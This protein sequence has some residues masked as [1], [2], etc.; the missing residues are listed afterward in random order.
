MS[1]H[2]PSPPADSLV[3][4]KVHPARVVSVGE[5]IEIAL[6]GGQSK[7]VRAKDLELLHPGPLRSLG[8]LVP[9]EGEVEAAWE[10]LEGS[11][12]SLQELAELA[13]S[14]FT[15]V[16]AWA[17]WQLV[18]EGLS[19][20]GT[21]GAIR[22]RPRAEVEYDRAQRDAK[23]VAEREWQAFLGRMAQAAPAPQDAGRLTEVE[24]LALGQS[25]RSRVLEALGH[26]QTPVNAHRALI[27]V[28]HWSDRHN[29]YPGR[30]S[31]PTAD[32]DLPVPAL[33]D[34]QRLDLTDLPA[35]AI[36][37]EGNQDPDD[38]VSLD[39]DRLW[40]HVADVAAL[41]APDGAVEREARARG[42]N[43]YLPERVINMLPQ[44]VTEQLGLGLQPVSPALSIALRCDAQGELTDIEVHRTWIRAQRLTYDAVDGRLGEAP[45]AAMCALTDRFRARRVALGAISLDLPEV[46]V[47]VVD[48]RVTIR[49]LPRL[50]S[51][52]LVTEAMLMAGE[53]VARF[54]RE[55]AIPI[56]Y[57][58]QVAPDAGDQPR[59]LAAMY[60]RR[61]TFKPTR[62]LI[63]PDLHAGLGLPLYT[64]ATSPLR[65]YSDLL[66]HQQ[67]CAWLSGQ[68]LLTAEQVTERIGEAEAAAG[69]VRRAER[70]SNLHWKLVFLKDHPDWQGEAIIV[71]KEE[72]KGVALIG[73]LALE[74]RLR[75]RD[76]PDLNQG[77]RVAVREV[78]VPD[79]T[80]SFRVL[81]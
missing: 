48:G 15:P 18:A 61:R 42:S 41:V 73:A 6:E 46:S 77:I 27:Q 8:E 75:L 19:F 43:L 30:C 9:Q 29:P 74:T 76:E 72:R 14:A 45:F 66:V 65:R 67:L 50:A 11:E 26:E 3:L 17:A 51:R 57:A 78:D 12:T 34:Q 33:P 63:I 21:P 5:K 7:R 55:H 32:P 40:V 58:T 68:P 28:G 64:R 71:G 4:Y 31:V 79:Q 44:G 56:S 16:T 53:G 70:L 54:C 52:G 20:T 1:S 59:D 10:L 38:A 62:M 81:G 23:A 39:G 36:D 80:V 35:Y 22:A 2:Q 24:R 69:T 49:P 13:F 60:A 25:E 37:D 47:R